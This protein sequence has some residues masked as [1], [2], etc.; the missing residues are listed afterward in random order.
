MARLVPAAAHRPDVQAGDE[1]PCRRE[2]VDGGGQR[3]IGRPGCHEKRVRG[4]EKGPEGAEALER[5]EKL[6][7]TSPA[8][9]C[10]WEKTD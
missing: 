7:R 1:S 3:G 2:H 4:A 6:P 10:L 9:Y 5:E 8:I